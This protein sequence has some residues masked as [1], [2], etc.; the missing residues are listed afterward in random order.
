VVCSAT[1]VP[2]LETW[3][4]QLAPDEVAARCQALGIPAARMAYPPDLLSDPHL[5]AR[6]FLSRSI[7]RVLARCASTASRT[8]RQICLC[9]RRDRRRRSESTPARSAMKS[10]HLSETEIEALFAAGVLE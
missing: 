5:A 6:G 2:E 9:R 4:A 1:E 8:S 7:S 3:C 10:F